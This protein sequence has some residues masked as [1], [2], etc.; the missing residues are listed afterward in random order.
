M[1]KNVCILVEIIDNSRNRDVTYYFGMFKKDVENKM[2]IS[3]KKKKN[4]MCLWGYCSL[5]T[6][7]IYL[8]LPVEAY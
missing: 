4:L 6:K 1:Y 8:S 3:K 5:L 7:Y 2:D